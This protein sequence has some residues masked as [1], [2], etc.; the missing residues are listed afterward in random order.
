MTSQFYDIIKNSVCKP[1]CFVNIDMGRKG[2]E[3][4]PKVTK[5]AVDLHQNGQTCEISELV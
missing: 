3:I 1:F 4:L 5:P 2:T